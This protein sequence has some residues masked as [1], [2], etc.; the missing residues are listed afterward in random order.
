MDR[1]DAVDR[2][3]DLPRHTDDEGVR[4]NDLV[5]AHERACSDDRAFAD[6]RARQHRR[7][8][9]DEDMVADLRAMHD[10]AV[11]DR[12]IVADDA[13]SVI[14]HMKADE[15][16]HIRALA[17]RD[18]V[19]IAACNDARPKARIL[20]DAHIARQEHLRRDEGLLVNLR[21]DAMKLHAGKR[22]HK[23]L[24]LSSIEFSCRILLYND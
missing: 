7:V 18:V 10:S 19:H 17:D 5:L 21:L 15:I 4:G 14:R 8:H 12:H 11:P 2:A 6:L 13:R 22:I 20:R 16:L 3:H 24:S 9:A 23:T 1:L